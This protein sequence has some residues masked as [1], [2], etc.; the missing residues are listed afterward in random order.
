V[1]PTVRPVVLS[2]GAG[3]RLWPLSTADRPK[4]FLELFGEPLFEATLKRLQGMVGVGPVTVVTGIDHL[5]QVER[6]AEIVAV[7]LASIVIEPVGRNT[8][9]AVVA[10]AFVSEPDDVLVVLPSDH[11]ITDIESF[12][13]VVETA[14]SLAT[15]GDLV[16][17][18]ALALRPETGYGYIEMGEPIE[19]GFRV[20]R[21]KEK[22][23]AS[24]AARM[25]ES[26]TH[27]WNSG[28]FVFTAGHLLDEAR[29]HSPRLVL[30]VE[31][32][33]PPERSGR[34]VLD[35]SFASVES[36]SIDHAVMEKTDKAVVIPMDVGWSDIGSWQSVWELTERDDAGNALAGDVTVVDVT[37]SYVVSTSKKVAVAGVDG[38]VVVE[39]PE[40]VL[41]V[42]MEKS[43]LVRDLVHRSEQDRA[44]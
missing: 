24:E 21:F 19:G 36:I 10:A 38:L 17:F 23:D 37:D 20:A 28:M 39:T 25:V 18:G 1:S 11:T 30:D 29:A 15:D 16:T 3:T 35:A 13:T 14:I 26:G 8:A 34:V 9:A 42:S 32:A 33:M 27:L 43:Q 4:Q 41:I 44:D 40:A 22:P 7:D 2:G 6:A 12:H 5:E 31:E